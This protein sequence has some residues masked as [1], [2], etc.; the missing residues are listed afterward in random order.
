[1]ETKT[2]DIHLAE[3]LLG[4]TQLDGMVTRRDGTKCFWFTDRYGVQHK[5]ATPR[6]K[7]N[8]LEAIKKRWRNVPGLDPNAGCLQ[9][10]ACHIDNDEL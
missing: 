3:L 4:N 9:A 5:Y 10:D 2:I 7:D 1:M 8:Q 6:P